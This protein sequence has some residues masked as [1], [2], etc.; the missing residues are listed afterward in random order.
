MSTDPA[1]EAEQALLAAILNDPDAIDRA[2]GIVDEDDF[3]EPV[4]RAI[5]AVAIR[6]RDEGQPVEPRSIIAELGGDNDLG[7][8]LTLR[9]YIARL[10]ASVSTTRNTAGYAREVREH[11]DRRR[12]ISVMRD[13]LATLEAAPT[14][15]RDIAASVMDVLDGIAKPPG[16]GSVRTIGSAATA[17]VQ[18]AR[19]A[20]RGNAPAGAT[21]GLPRLDRMTGVLRPGQLVIIAARPGMGKS[22][23]ASVIARNAALLGSGVSFFSLEMS[24]QEVAERLL[25]AVA[26]DLTGSD[27]LPYTKIRAGRDL[28]VGDFDTLEAAANELA[29]LPITIDETPGISV[30]Q[31][32][33]RARRAKATMER[34]GVPMRLLVVDHIGLVRASSRYAGNRVHEIAETT[35]ALKVL[36]KELGVAVLALSQ[37]SRQ[38]EGRADKRP[39]LS[40]LRDSGSIEQD[41]DLVIGLFRESYYLERE[42]NRTLEQDA[43]LRAIRNTIDVEVLKNRMGP[44]GSVSLI[45]AL[46]SN[47]LKDREAA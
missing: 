4:H 14:P 36:A 23:F 18:A 45:C 27:V 11:A 40:D 21:F 38:T 28:R 15:P 20:Q 29:R 3:A 12:V 46:G 2:R 35:G 10:V 39:Q 26:F 6:R 33:A 16:A 47:V 1:I 8:G 13:A 44:T 32:A 5:F 31:I 43:R 9:A 22:T 34:Q 25:S 17:A 30:A 41:A 37:L 42:Q 19:E 7:G 24:H